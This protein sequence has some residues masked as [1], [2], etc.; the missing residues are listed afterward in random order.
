MLAEE[1]EAAGDHLSSIMAQ[2]R[3]VP[4]RFCAS[5]SPW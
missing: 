3:R 4:D 1:A 2:S 5:S